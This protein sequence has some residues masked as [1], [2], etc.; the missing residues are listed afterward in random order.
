MN[1]YFVAISCRCVYLHIN[2]QLLLNKSSV[3]QSADVVVFCFFFVFFFF[4]IVP[5]IH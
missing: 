4:F 5:Y 2:Y 3:F 1:H